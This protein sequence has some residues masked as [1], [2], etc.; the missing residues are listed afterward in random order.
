M[1]WLGNLS[2]KR[3]LHL[4]VVISCVIMTAIAL[5]GL[6]EQRNSALKDRKAKLESQ[7]EQTVALVDYYHTLIPQLGEEAAKAHALDAIKALRYDGKNYFWIT[8]QSLEVLMHPIKPA[9]IG[10]DAT[11]F[12]D[13]N[14]KYHWQ[15]MARISRST[16]H[17]FLDYSWKSPDG[18][19][20]D[21]VSYVYYVKDWDWI[22]GS[23]VLVSDINEAF[24]SNIFKT[25]MA[26][27]IGTILLGA[28]SMLIGKNIV[29]PIEYLLN[30]VHSISNGD[31]TIRFHT[32]RKDEIGDISRDMNHMLE[33]L[34]SALVLASSSA[35]D[36]VDMVSSIASS[37]EQTAH[38]TNAQHTQL[39]LLAT[40]MNQMST[41]NA[42]VSRNAGDAS[43]TTESVAGLAD[44]SSKDMEIV[45]QSIED[46]DNQ[47]ALTSELVEELNSGVLA[48]A[49]VVDVIRGISEQTNLLALNAA[50]EAARAGEYGRGFAVVADEVRTLATNT[51]NSTEQIQESIS[52]LT[53]SA[54]NASQAVSSGRE[55]VRECVAKSERTRNELI[56]MIEILTM[57]NDMVTQIASSSEEQ[58][59]VSNEINENI[60]AISQS[61]HEV[62]EAATGVAGQTQVLVGNADQLNQSLRY[63]S[64]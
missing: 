17:G 3:K 55:K 47:M 31:M 58:H 56:S 19:I 52:K 16:Q 51:N 11:N 15:E 62:R 57:A 20:L 26:I 1:A 53:S 6:M 64:V 2:I 5:Y 25:A 61:A 60:V 42:E 39:E 27:L 49:E 43:A 41:A 10:K 28:V 29:N 34:Q 9:L 33:R 22:I 46:A 45:V 35:N 50:I 48:I 21:K 23:G 37:S 54:S 14:G 24:F 13:G 32:K 36:S 8:S 38:S 7:V 4:L 63:F 12:K 40:A 18:E 59:A 30:K 44:K